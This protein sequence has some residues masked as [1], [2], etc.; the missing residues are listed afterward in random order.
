[1]RNYL[2]ETIRDE[3]REG[4]RHDSAAAAAGNQPSGDQVGDDRAGRPVQGESETQAQ[5]RVV[6][7]PLASSLPLEESYQRTVRPGACAAGRAAGTREA[8]GMRKR[9]IGVLQKA[10]A[11]REN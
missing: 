11:V 8:M 1:M 9:V 4:A 10:A 5:F 3:V 2:R 6:L 7:R